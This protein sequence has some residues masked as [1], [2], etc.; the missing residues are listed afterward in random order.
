MTGASSRHGE[1]PTGLITASFGN[2]GVTVYPG[3]SAEDV[4]KV[5][6]VIQ[7]ELDKDFHGHYI[8][9]YLAR[10]IAREV[11]LCLNKRG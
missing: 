3:Q 2:I 1:H 4:L 11:L 6:H 10:N 8:D 7:S 5:A 9:H